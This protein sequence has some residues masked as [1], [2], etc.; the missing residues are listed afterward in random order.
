[1]M[2]NNYGDK[3]KNMI[4]KK[5]D[6]ISVLVLIILTML[7][8]FF[9]GYI[10]CYKLE[11]NVSSKEMKKIMKE[12]DYIT[13]NYEGKIDKDE[14][15]EG[16]IKG[17][18]E[19][20]DDKYSSVETGEDKILTGEY[21]GLGISIAKTLDNETVILEIMKGGSAEDNKLKVGD[22]IIKID[23]KKTENLTNSEI[24]EYIT[25]K[26]EVNITIKR[27]DDEFIVKLSKKK[28][29]LD[30]INSKIIEENKNIGYIQIETFA[31]NTAKQFE[32]HLK[33]LEKS[34][35]DTLIIDLRY[36]GGG[37]LSTTE[38]II[39]LLVDNKKIAYQTDDDGKIEKFYSKG[40]QTTNLDV[41]IMINGYSASG[42]EMLAASLK[43]NINATLV[44]QKSFGKGT[45]QEVKN[46]DEDSSYKITTKYWLTPKG[47]NIN[48]KGLV[49]DVE[50]KANTDIIT[51]NELE[52]TIKY[53]TTK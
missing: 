16:A 12:Y 41:V 14:I 21:I 19:S 23:D 42:S 27:K 1:M 39:A 24:V 26:E 15:V 40:T 29:I 52:E 8:S 35:I 11:G 37:Y 50:L 38:K 34:N 9:A 32:E 44:G 36:N 13:N 7:I 30:S 43:D 10:M 47:K 17:M 33:K 46:I 28:I 51:D 48:E 5:Y 49:P 31:L 25:K 22:Y 3:M 18:L 53:I 2:Y 20:L 45:V 4:I 6:T